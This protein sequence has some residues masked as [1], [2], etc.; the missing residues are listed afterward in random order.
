MVQEVAILF[1]NYLW[2][3]NRSTKMSA[4]NFNAFKSNNYP[5]LAKIGLGIHFS[6][7]A[8]MRAVIKRPLKVR[9]ELDTNV[10]FLDL[11]P[12]ISE[13]I[14]RHQLG[15][16]GIKGIVLK[17]FGAGNAPTAQWFTDAI[18]EAVDRGIVIVNITQCVNGGV[19]TKRYVSGDRLAAT[20]VISGH[21]MTSEAAITKMMYLFGLGLEAAEVRKYL[22][23]SLCGEV[24]L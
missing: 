1:E 2:R 12:G 24:T 9:Y 7:D 23:C 22:E 21:D 16:P 14:L 4:D 17:T 20:G 8:L 10:M 6:E 18:R 19:H 5:P 13:E 3:G 15:T 11:N